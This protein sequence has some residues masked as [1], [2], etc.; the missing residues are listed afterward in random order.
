MNKY[1]IAIVNSLDEINKIFIIKA[2]TSKQA[3]IKALSKYKKEFIAEY[4]PDGNEK[5]NIWFNYA[6]HYYNIEPSPTIG[7]YSNQ[8]LKISKPIKL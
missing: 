7:A 8:L 3:C 5:D 4:Y 2:D 6:E 1:A